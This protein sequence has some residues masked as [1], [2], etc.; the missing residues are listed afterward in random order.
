MRY[1][2]IKKAIQEALDS[3][4]FE[5]GMGPRNLRQLASQIDARVGIEFE[6]CVPNAQA[7]R[8]E[9]DFDSDERAS[10]FDDIYEFFKY[11]NGR[12]TTRSVI[13]DLEDAYQEWREEAIDHRWDRVSLERVR[14][15]IAE[16]DLFEPDE[17]SAAELVGRKH[18]NLDPSSD[19]FA[20]AVQDVMSRQLDQFAEQQVQEGSNIYYEARAEFADEYEDTLGEYVFLEE[21]YPYMSDVYEAFSSQIDW[22]YRNEGEAD[23]EGVATEFSHAV[24]VDVSYSDRYHGAKRDTSKYIVEPDSS[25]DVKSFD[26]AGLEF[27]SPPLPLPRMIEDLH[28]VRAW[29]VDRGCYT[30]SSTGL[31][32][33][34]SVPGFD[35]KRLDYTKLVLMLGDQYVLNQFNRTTNQYALSSFNRL[36]IE[37]N[38]DPNRALQALD[39][40]RKQFSVAASQALSGI[41]LDKYFSVH[42]RQGWVEFRGPGGDWLGANFNKIE[43]TILRFVVALDAAL[44]PQKYRKEYLKKLYTLL[45]PYTED[46]DSVTLFAQYNSGAITRDQLIQK[47][48]AQRPAAAQ[49]ATRA[50]AATAARPAGNAPAGSP[51]L[52]DDEFQNFSRHLGV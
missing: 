30:N 32:I 1:N 23:I 52:S 4:L 34:V 42:I 25:I 6:M 2:E 20:D 33:N 13:D 27:V 51:D 41:P 15:Y 17:E 29:A 22:P 16:H 36:N 26:D 49:P 24:G 28:R 46:A 31:H 43:N 3:E 44:N 10:S 47:L 11:E 50:G 9:L 5:V 40:M 35:L 19:K 48:K 45:A 18:P 39:Q 14:D 21:H 7:E 12:Q 8:G 38:R 37:V